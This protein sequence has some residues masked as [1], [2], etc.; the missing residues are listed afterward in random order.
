MYLGQKNKLTILR[1]TAPGAY[2]ADDEGNE[3]LLPNKYLTENLEIAQEIEVFI[4]KDSEERIVA[5]TDEPLIELYGFAY[6]KC[7]D[8][9]HLG[10]FVDWGMEK[11]L[12][13]P[14]NEQQTK[15]EEGNSY[16]TY[17]GIDDSTQRLYG[18]TKYFR[19]LDNEHIV[20]ENGQEVDLLVAGFSSLGCK[21]IIND[22]YEGLIFQNQLIRP[23]QIGEK[24][25]GFVKFIRPDGKVDVVLE[26]QGRH[27]IEDHSSA[28]LNYLKENNN[29]SKI[30]EKSSPE[31]I[32][33]TFG[34]S[35]KTFK[36]A[37]GNLYKERKINLTP[38]EITLLVNKI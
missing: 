31:E 36:Q 17:L 34:M 3:V 33:D 6:L 2:L 1:F 29:I 21:V 9:N 15:L 20:I 35:K 13:V 38:Q 14:Y 8:V 7:V 26:R 23:L 16:I 37:L 19:Y 22:S 28:I 25:T 10:A 32:R 30:T 24:T 12:F 18:S 4:Y 5:V 11:H 27:K